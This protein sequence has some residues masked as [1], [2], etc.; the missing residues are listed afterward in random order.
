MLEDSIPVTELLQSNLYS[1]GRIEVFQ[2]GEQEL[3]RDKITWEGSER[4][5]YH[6][7][8]NSDTIDTIAWKY[9]NFLVER[10]ERFWWIIADANDVENPLDLSDL[11]GSEIVIPDIYNFLLIVNSN[12]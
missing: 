11:V 2:N 10:S 9:Y 6:T 3:V 5:K 12:G 1:N 7:V 4:D 8:K